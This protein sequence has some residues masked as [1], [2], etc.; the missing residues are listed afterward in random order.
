[1]K[2]AL[3]LILALVMTMSLVAC[4]GNNA[5]GEE[6][7]SETPST[8]TTTPPTTQT[9]TGEKPADPSDENKDRIVHMAVNTEFNS[10]DPHNTTA[11]CPHGFRWRFHPAEYGQCCSRDL[12]EDCGFHRI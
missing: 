10:L 2:K 7:K 1:M 11:A 8:S 4:G 6:E 12:P 9:S 3:A 5:G